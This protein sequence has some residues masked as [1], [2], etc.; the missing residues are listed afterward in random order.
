MTV[1]FDV[2]AA[3]GGESPVTVTCA[4]APGT[5]FALGAATVTC[6]AQDA[7]NRRAECSFRVSVTQPRLTATRFLAFGDSLTAGAVSHAPTLLLLDLP[8]S[9][10]FK[11]HRS[12]VTRYQSQAPVVLN[13]G[14]GGEVAATGGRARLPGSL[15]VNRPDILLL[16]EG[17]ND[18][19][20]RE[21]GAAAAL[22]ALEDM[23]RLAKGRRVRVLLATIPPQR[24][25]GLRHRDAVAALIPSFNDSIRQL[26]TREGLTIVDVYDA[27]KD[28]LDLIGVD[29]LHPTPQGYDVMAATFLNTIRAALEE[30]R[31]TAVP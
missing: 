9:Y 4:P 30:S 27:L 24:A 18:L 7:A 14:F 12:L 29:D 26:A 19:L 16:M 6:V 22:V 20:G 10:P 5:P 21:S 25:G 15:D 13:D 2:P 1:A 3:V 17:T 31:T 23:V 11:L 28:R 8:D